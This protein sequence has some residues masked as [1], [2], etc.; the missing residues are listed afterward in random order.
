MRILYVLEHYFP[1]VGGAETL[2]TS[3]AEAMAHQGHDVKVVTTR[4]DPNLPENEVINGVTIRRLNC[5][6]R[7]YFTIVAGLFLW[8]SSEKYDIIHTT[9]YNAAIPAW[10][11]S[12]K[13]KTPI[14]LTFHEVWGKLW[15]QL[16]FLTWWQRLAFFTYEKLVSLLPFSHYVAVS[17]STKKDLIHHGIPHE[18]ITR[19]YNGI[20][21][22]IFDRLELKESEGTAFNFLFFG[23]LGVSKG[24]DLLV[25]AFHELATS[26]PDARL[27]LILPTAP[28]SILMKVKQMIEAG[29]IEHSV[30]VK[31][32]LSK[33]QLYQEVSHANCVVVPSY[34]EGFCF[35]AVETIGMGVPI[36]SS[37]R[38]AL[39]EVVGG[40]HLTMKEMDV[41]SLRHSMIS[42]LEGQW[43]VTDAP[44]FE[45]A[46]S[47]KKYLTLYKNVFE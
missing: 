31:H 22:S 28:A 18:K 13:T 33:D 32:D 34:S 36:I 30:R 9:T 11:M 20:D 12:L 23:R 8:K 45:L 17:E 35:V 6:N 27:T 39:K 25:P 41:K 43:E 40:R 4:H 37:G 46:E 1:Y 7:F 24:L 47:V 5:R 29:P 44:R 2:F 19:I 14:I 15:F 42:A 38:K 26:H 21:Y 16:P 3:L 10:F